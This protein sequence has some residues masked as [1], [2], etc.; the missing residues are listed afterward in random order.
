MK[1]LFFF[2]YRKRE[3]ELVLHAFPLGLE[4]KAQYSFCLVRC[5]PDQ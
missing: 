3:A 5:P 2:F 1:T 4:W